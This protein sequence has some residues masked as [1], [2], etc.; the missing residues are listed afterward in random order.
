MTTARVGI[1]TVLSVTVTRL[2]FG[3]SKPE[4]DGRVA[5][6]PETGRVDMNRATRRGRML[7]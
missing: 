4:A 3:Q 5:A 1:S 6:Q 2:R 7:C